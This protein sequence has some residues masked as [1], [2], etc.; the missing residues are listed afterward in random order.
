MKKKLFL[1]ANEKVFKKNKNFY[2][3]NYDEKSIP[4]GLNKLFDLTYIVRN[5]KKFGASKINLK[6]IIVSNNILAFFISIIKTLKHKDSNYLLVS[7]SPITFLSFL[8]LF[9]SRKKIFVY[10]R[11]SG[12]EEYKYIFGSWSTWIYNFMFKIVTKGSKVIVCDKR[13]YNGKCFIVLPSK[14]DKKW[15]SSKKSPNLNKINYLYV[16][17]I[18]PEKGIL[19]FI[20]MFKKLNLNS[21]LSL[22]SEIN[23]K[24][25][26]N[27]IS[28]IKY[29]GHGF[30]TDKL[31]KIF[32]KNNIM[33]LP[34]FTE[35]HPQVVIESLARNRP[36]IIFEDIKHIIKS[37]KGIF[38]A[39]RSVSDLKKTTLYI[40]KNYKKIQKQM[41]LNKLPTR[42]VFFKSI[43]SILNKN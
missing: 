15:L 38:V 18:N 43:A 19:N 17:R 39:K 37:R 34:S 41:E 14:I 12:H 20:N 3:S 27:K 36:V 7:I 33:I 9:F 1:V 31:I 24:K 2:C 5:T 16:G 42:D 21:N 32:D 35:G 8:I 4:E 10:L 40:I 28:N 26:L 22:V 25:K 30:K 29:L 11:S 6:K 23:D 13:L